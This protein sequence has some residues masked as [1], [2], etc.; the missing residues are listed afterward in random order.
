MIGIFKQKNPAN[1]FVLLVFG[2]LIKLPMF[3]HPYIPVTKPADGALFISLLKFLEPTGKSSP[4]IYPLL[5]FG[6]LYLQAVVLTRFVNSQRMVNRSTYLSGMSYLLITSLLPDWNYFSAPLLIN[7]ILL[8]VLTSLFKI[9]NQSSAK[10][11]IFNIGVALGIAGFLFISSLTFIIWVLLALAVMRPFRLNEWLLCLLGITTPFYFYGLYIFITDEWS[12][13]ALMPHI[14]IGIPAIK[15]SA[16]L[17]GSV[18][19]LMIPFLTGGYYVQDN[20][21]RMLINVR[22]GW[23]LLLL[24]LL[25]SLLLPFVNN[26]DTFENWVMAMIPMAAFHTCTYLY[27]TLR[28]YPNLLFWI[29]IAFVLTYQYAGPG[30]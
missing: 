19:L 27:S 29:S 18:F 9:Y 15:Q 11:T 5:T 20:L 13:K 23:S 28:I 1:L 24:Y 6:F 30:W 4:V 17:A 21:R 22:K 26:S 7:S 12:W 10:G 8:F 3:L 25:V 14:S 16:W 2:V